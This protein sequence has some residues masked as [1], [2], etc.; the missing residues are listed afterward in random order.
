MLPSAAELVARYLRTNGYTETLTSFINEA[1]LAPDIGSTSHKDVTIDQI[2]QEKKVFDLSLTFE[3]TGI[4][5]G[6]R[7]WKDPAIGLGASTKSNVLSVSVLR[8]V[9]PSSDEPRPYIATTTADRKLNLFNPESPDFPIAHSY[10]SFQDSPILDVVVV[11]CKYLLAASMSGKLTLF[12][13]ATDQILGE[14]KDHSKYLVKLAS[15]PDGDSTFIAS[16]GWDAKVFVYRLRTDPGREP[17][18]SEPIAAITLQSIPETVLFVNSPNSSQPILLVTRRDSTFLYYYDVP[19]SDTEASEVVLL[20]KQNLAPHSNAWI[21]FT[22]SDVQVSPVDPT[23]VA[24]GTSSTPHMKLLVVRL[25][26]PPR[27]ALRHATDPV[28][29]RGP[30]TQAA[31][32]RADLAIQD[33]E[34]AAI[35]ISINTMAPQTA[36]STPRLVWRPDGSGI[37]VSSDDGIIRGFEATT[38]K[39]VANLEAHDKGSK[40]RCLWA[41]NLD[42][43]HGE[44]GD[45][46]SPGEYLLSGGFDQNMFLWSQ[47]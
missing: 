10:T 23:I 7:G 6:E 18:I 15:W 32:A 26:L 27:Q 20:G 25:L 38:G 29:D 9:L 44:N 46:V 37:Y 45:R 5:D 14:R 13:T 34:E 31:Q 11:G 3:R 35:K 39:L 30:V 36:Y 21:A 2:L 1:G 33:R 42:M 41:G 24:V 22:P 47:N 4:N 43:A 8:L 12:N 40:L 28:P 19:V 17:L 16:A